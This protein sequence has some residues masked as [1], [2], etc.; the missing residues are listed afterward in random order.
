MGVIQNSMNTMLATVMGGVLGM[1]HIKGQ[2]AAKEAQ[3]KAVAA[4][5]KKELAELQADIPNIKY[6]ELKE[7]NIEK[8]NLKTDISDKKT[9][10]D[11]AVMEGSEESR[12][13]ELNKDINKT[14]NA[15]KVTEGKIKGKKMQLKLKE[16]RFQELGQKYPETLIGGKK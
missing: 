6:G 14:S 9:I 12:I 3:L 15:L 11:L 8:K 13:E 4:T 10:R 7:L 16:A 2:E 1:Q 5:E